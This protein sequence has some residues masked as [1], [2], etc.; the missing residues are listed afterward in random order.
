MNSGL[1]EKVVVSTDSEEI[2]NIALEAGAEVP[3]LRPK[4]I[5]DDFTGT[6]PVVSHAIDYL[7]KGGSEYGRM[8][9]IFN[10][11][12]RTEISSLMEGFDKIM[13]TKFDF[14]FSA[15]SFPFPP[16]RSFRLSDQDRVIS[17]FKKDV[18]KKVPRFSGVVP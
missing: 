4:E 11:S 12:F 10:C 5:S 2:A 8:L 6:N 1:F 17:N 7:K 9:H 16:Q 13:K 3:F 14:V 15:T 18:H